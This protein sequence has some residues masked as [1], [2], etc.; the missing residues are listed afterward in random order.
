MC[1][2]YTNTCFRKIL[3]NLRDYMSEIEAL[4]VAKLP[5][6]QPQHLS[7]WSDRVEPP[8]TPCK[9]ATAADIVQMEDEA[10]G[11]KFREIRAKISQ[12]VASMTAY[13]AKIEANKKREHVVMVMHE[14][15]QM[16]VG[17]EFLIQTFTIGTN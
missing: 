1:S 6:W 17:K 2:T 14:R 11:A 4:I 5:S 3:S 15:S 9:V 10:Q 16:Q 8:A 7:L 13:N 12:D